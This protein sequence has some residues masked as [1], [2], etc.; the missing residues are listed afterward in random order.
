MQVCHVGSLSPFARRHSVTPSADATVL[1]SLSPRP[2]SVT[3]RKPGKL[4]LRNRQ[5][6]NKIPS[7]IVAVNTTLCRRDSPTIPPRRS[8]VNSPACLTAWLG[9][10]SD[11]TKNNKEDAWQVMGSRSPTDIPG[12]PTELTDVSRD[13]CNWRAQPAQVGSSQRNKAWS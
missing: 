3:S 9:I 1:M 12:A 6:I 2:E 5:P 13:V 4:R 8:A 10:E 11:P 7:F